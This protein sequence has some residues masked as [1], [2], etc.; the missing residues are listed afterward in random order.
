VKRVSSAAACDLYMFKLLQNRTAGRAL[1]TH[2]AVIMS[3]FSAMQASALHRLG[4]SRLREEKMGPRALTK[5]YMRRLLQFLT[6]GTNC[7]IF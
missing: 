2:I 6:L 5:V 4:S 3:H 1:R 7:Y